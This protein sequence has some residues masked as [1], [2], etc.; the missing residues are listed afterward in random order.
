MAKPTY[1]A[2][3][4]VKRENK[5]DFWLNIGVC[6]AHEDKAGPSSEVSSIHI[7]TTVRRYSACRR[8]VVQASIRRKR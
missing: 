1:R 6:F 8:R 4:V 5:D 7:C 3:T 2:Y